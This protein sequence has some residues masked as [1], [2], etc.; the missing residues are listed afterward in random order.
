[1]NSYI[2]N[3]PLQIANTA[4]PELPVPPSLYGVV[5]FIVDTLVRELIQRAMNSPFLP[6]QIPIHQRY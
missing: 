4:D 3:R 5:Y 1:M 6:I 2:Y